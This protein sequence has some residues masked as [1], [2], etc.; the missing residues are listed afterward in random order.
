[1]LSDHPVAFQ[2]LFSPLPVHDTLFFDEGPQQANIKSRT[3]GSL[4]GA[5]D[6]R[7]VD[8][9]VQGVEI[10]RQSQYDAG[11]AKIWSGEPGHQLRTNRFGMDK[12][13]FP[14][15]GYTELDLF[16]P[17]RYLR[18]Q[19]NLSP[20]WWNIL[21]FPIITGDNDQAENYYFNG[22][23]E[24]LTIRA[25]VAHFSTEAPYE[26]HSVKGLF[27][28]G[29]GNQLNGTDSVVS[30]YSFEPGREHVGY[31]DMVDILNSNT[32]QS[33]TFAS[34]SWSGGVPLSGTYVG[35]GDFTP[36][37]VPTGRP[38]NGFFR[39]EFTSILPFVDERLIRNTADKSQ[40]S[41]HQSPEMLAALSLMTG[42][43]DN[44]VRHT[45]RSAPCGWYYD[46]N[47]GVGTDS[48]TFGGQTY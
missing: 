43:T 14:D 4:S 31:L 48:L 8:P 15:P 26:S 22:I 10:T 7:A 34:G 1:M 6:T 3:T 2:P 9:Y 13:F 27:G 32:V 21:T 16:D 38:L 39:F 11:I 23:I 25:V 33:G 28:N 37:F 12:N 30:V 29:N 44:Y 35:E 19:E 47:G 45:Q 36:V 17:V 42:S 18:A 24:P 20:L 40:V 41:G 46:D 5:M